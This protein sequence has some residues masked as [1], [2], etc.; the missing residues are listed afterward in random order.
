MTEFLEEGDRCNGVERE[1]HPAEQLRLF[2]LAHA[3][4]SVMIQSQVETISFPIV[5]LSINSLYFTLLRP[6]SQHR[7]HQLRTP[8]YAT[9]FL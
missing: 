4:I 2:S 8:L 1:V 9:Y 3:W 6:S 5:E 7:P